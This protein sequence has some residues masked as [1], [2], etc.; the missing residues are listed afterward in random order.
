M[1]FFF[2]FFLLRCKS[3]RV[4]R[5]TNL[6]SNRAVARRAASQA[7]VA[8]VDALAAARRRAEAV[9][10]LPAP[11]DT[12]AV[13]R[14]RLATRGVRR[15]RRRGLTGARHR[16]ADGARRVDALVACLAVH[17]ARNAALPLR[18]TLQDH[19]LHALPRAVR[20]LHA[21]VAAPAGT[22]C[23]R[24]RGRRPRDAPL[25]H[26]VADG[27]P[28]LQT[29][30]AV[31]ALEPAA[32]AARA[33]AHRLR[34]DA[35]EAFA[36]TLV[37]VHALDPARACRVRTRRGRRVHRL[38]AAVQILV[39]HGA[40]RRKA[41]RILRAVHAAPGAAPAEGCAG[42][43]EEGWSR[44]R[45]DALRALAERAVQVDAAGGVAPPVAVGGCRRRHHGPAADAVGPVADGAHGV[46]A[47]RVRGARHGAAVAAHA[48]GLVRRLH[49]LVAL[50]QA[51]RVDRAL[52]QARRGG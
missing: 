3:G 27:A 42:G 36:R 31:C 9:E 12:V 46:D 39:A 21:L 29:L 7:A 14:T 51:L 5:R 17:A 24:R 49:A 35:L 20:V 38:L 22:G 44:C 32:H 6:V 47:V 50:T 1:I 4:V 37:V 28:L 11:S 16:V 45:H 2:F 19:A 13:R 40:A 26:A 33:N 15:R 34:Q 41:V 18:R 10:A 23:R 48:E 43:V 25:R 30:A 52:L 8:V